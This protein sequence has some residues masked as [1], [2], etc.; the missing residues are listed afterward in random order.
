[1]VIG[2]TCTHG[3]A[4]LFPFLGH[5]GTRPM[6]CTGAEVNTQ[7]RLPSSRVLLTRRWFYTTSA[8]RIAE[9]LPG[10]SPGLRMNLEW[11]RNNS[12]PS[13]ILNLFAPTAWPRLSWLTQKC[14]FSFSWSTFWQLQTSSSD[15]VTFSSTGDPCT[16]QGLC[17]RQ[18]WKVVKNWAMGAK[19]L[20][21]NSGLATS[22]LYHLGQ[23]HSGAL[24]VSFAKC[25]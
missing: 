3:Y 9:G 6:T 2:T 10:E 11:T 8:S 19:C 18:F 16:M 20:P 7:L 24:L 13:E 4:D 1:M 22:W 23:P 17:S 5:M 15:M 21:Y 14:T 25:R 12:G